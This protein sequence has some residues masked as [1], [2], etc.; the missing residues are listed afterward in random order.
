MKKLFL[1]LMMVGFAAG[2]YAQATTSA[3]A[4]ATVV[5]PISISKTVDMSFGNVAV[6]S[7]AGGTV[8]LDT[9]DGT[10]TTGDVTLPATAGTI[11]SASF[12]IAGEDGYTYAITLPTTVNI[13]DAVSSEIMELSSFTSAPDATGTLTGGAEVLKVGATLT[14]GAGQVSGAY[15]GSFDVTVNYN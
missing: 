5:T 15:T 1:L 9:N 3:T 14:V 2:A 4:S 11:T 13:T 12:G 7:D 10:S 6:K 8:V